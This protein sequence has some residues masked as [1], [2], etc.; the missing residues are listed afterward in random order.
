M[1]LTGMTRGRSERGGLDNP[2]PAAQYLR[3][4]TDKQCYSLEQQSALIARFAASHGFNIVQTYQ[5]AARSGVTVT[6]RAGLR[7]LLKDVVDNPPYQA[8]LVLDV[9]RWGR[10]QDPDE[11]AHYEFICRAAGVRLLYCA[12]AFSNDQTLE[13]NIAKNLKRLM[14][15]EYSRQLS[16][17]CREGLARAARSGGRTGGPVPYGFRRVSFDPVTQEEFSLETGQHKSRPGHRVRA[18]VG[19]V[20][21]VEVIR[22]IFRMLVEDVLSPSRIATALN[23]EGIPHRLPGAWNTS[24]V[25]LVL[26]NELVIGINVRNRTQQTL[27]RR[28]K[29][30]SADWIRSSMGKPIISRALFDQAQ[31][32][33]SRV[34]RIRHTDDE[35]IAMMQAI[36]KRYGTLSRDLITAHAAAHLLTFSRRFGSLTA[37]YRAA[38]FERTNRLG[39]HIDKTA[40]EPAAI[41][42]GLRRLL[43]EQG[44]LSQ[45]LIDK[46]PYL[47]HSK[48]ITGR[49]GQ[50][51]PIYKSI[52][53]NRTRSEL[54]KQAWERRR[55][56]AEFLKAAQS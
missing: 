19:P 20:S 8:I 39:E 28:Q 34:H 29:M 50:L 56:R 1:E 14:A 26:R 22:R 13:A 15:G 45:A 27:G 9:S 16:D 24:R 10:F 17:R 41:T 54:L 36:I 44:Y 37:A 32:R 23:E 25:K 4:S 7:A 2:V 49:M 51:L 35:L 18:V 5:D 3:M 42:A 48:T 6:K 30:K 52:G 21:E 46:A 55:G 11:A 43:L 12:E 33:L 38:G 53:Y 40:L 31:D 47:P